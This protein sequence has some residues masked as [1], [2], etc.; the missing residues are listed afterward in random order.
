MYALL[1]KT[2]DRTTLASW[3]GEG[4]FT[5]AL[6]SSFFGFF[7]HA[8]FAL[9]LHE[10]G[11]RPTKITGASAGA[12]VGAALASGLTPVETRDILFA[13]EKKEFWD[14]GLGLGFLR[15][16]KFR[17]HLKRHLVPSFQEAH[18]SLE[19]AAFD[20]VSM[21][22][23]FLNEGPLAPAVAA[24]CAVPLMFHPAKV[25]GRWFLDG[26]MFNKLGINSGPN[27]R[28]LCVYL[29]AD[30]VTGWFE[31]Q[32]SFRGLQGHH[33]ILRFTKFPKVSFNSLHRGHDAFK[34]IYERSRQA[35]R[36]DC[37]GLFLNA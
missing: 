5:L 3:I 8:G 2:I 28:T 29:E 20:V 9:A 15:G 22:T 31:R 19:V 30:G 10:L 27:E 37:P 4:P 26:G 14:P 21:K 34:N 11:A 17:E 35:F 7:A 25:N 12:L 23:K 36:A 13:L 32:T 24:S 18:I 6:S 1:M 16:L 33:K